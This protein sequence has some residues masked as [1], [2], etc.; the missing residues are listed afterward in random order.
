M[1]LF[2]VLSFTLVLGLV[3]S[4]SLDPATLGGSE[5]TGSKPDGGAKPDG[6]V[7]GGDY[8]FS[9][10]VPLVKGL[11]DGF[12]ALMVQLRFVRMLFENLGM[13]FSRIARNTTSL[14]GGSSIPFPYPSQYGWLGRQESSEDMST[15][16]ES[17]MT[18]VNNRFQEIF[19]KWGQETALAFRN[20]LQEVAVVYQDAIASLLKQ[21]EV[22]RHQVVQGYQTL[23]QAMNSVSSML[24]EN[25]PG[26]SAISSSIQG[27][28]ASFNQNMT[29]IIGSMLPGLP[30]LPS[31][32]NLLPSSGTTD[33]SSKPSSV[34][35]EPSRRTIRY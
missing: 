35:Q 34:D 8:D 4:Q 20:L 15:T 29:Q 17:P 10:F 31:I 28:T 22:S 12:R 25:F 13:E 9:A 16:T 7:E 23:R 30:T 26:A 3:F 27:L 24:T 21:G 18:N 2:S 32:S 1:K 5:S 11:I 33:Q 14:G 6:A 19:D